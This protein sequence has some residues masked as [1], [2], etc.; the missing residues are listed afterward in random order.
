MPKLTPRALSLLLSTALACGGGGGAPG[1]DAGGGPDAGGTRYTPPSLARVDTIIDDGWVFLAADAAGAEAPGFD[2]T[3]FLPVTLPHTWNALDG[4]D[5][6]NDYRRGVGWYRRHLAGAAL[7]APPG[8][9]IY[10]QFD[11]ANIVADVYVNGVMVGEHRGGFATFRFDVTDA[12]DPAGDDVLAVKVDNSAF[13]D[14]PP[15]SA[16]F[17]FFGGLYRDVHLVAVD[18]LHVDLDDFGASGVTLIPSDVTPDAAALA[19]RVRVTNAGTGGAAAEVALAIV[20]PDG[21]LVTRLTQTAALDPGTT[22]EIA[23]STT[24]QTPAL[25]NGRAA[26]SLYTAYAEVTAGGVVT[27]V[28]AQP[29]GLRAFAVDP[30]AGFSLNGVPLDLHGVNRHQDRLDKGWAITAADHDE[31]MA[32][33]AEVG[34]T[35][36]RLAHYQHAQHFYDLC[37]RYGM[38]VWAEVPVVNAVTDSAAFTAN[39]EQQ[40]RELIRQNV[41]HP[42]IFF[43]SLSNEL[44]NTA[45]AGALLDDLDALA[46][47]EDPSRPTTVASNQADADPITTHADLVG[48]N[49]YYGWYT[50]TVANFAP[51]ADNFHAAFPARAA[52]VSEFGAGAG[53]TI[54]SAT[55]T[56]MDHS[57]EYECLFH[58]TYWQAMAARPFLWGKFVWNMFDFASDGRNEG[59]TPG[60]NDKGLVTY[61]RQTR[62]DAFYWYKANWSAD[63]VVYITERRFDPRTTP[64]IDVKVYSNLDNVALTVNGTAL[65]AQTS[66]NHIF[67]FPGVAL[68]AGVNQVVATA[69]TGVISAADTVSWTRQ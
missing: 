21:T 26:P 7:G 32:L 60:R 57:E 3:G 51:W 53:V 63:P 37:D 43:W 33:I 9:R 61:D 5:G 11:G 24:I 28:V 1:A 59:E 14:V 22:S 25:W 20:G 27:D 48:F 15:L 45:A 52:A 66:P 39:A 68:E 44:T 16:D 8:G 67:V 46:H 12:L 49:K 18:G 58:E 47:D 13:A 29:F 38:V 4:E 23:L 17:T 50:G 69:M 10:L 64:T 40:L 31:D 41:N 36:I 19:G 54:H 2:D 55:P 65:P 56:V 34:A 42:S 35:A 62:K 6:G 30:A